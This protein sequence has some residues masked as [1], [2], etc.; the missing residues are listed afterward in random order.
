MG[1]S[2]KNKTVK[3]LGWHFA[4]EKIMSLVTREKTKKKKGRSVE[5]PHVVHSIKT[6]IPVT[7]VCVCV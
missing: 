5:R 7:R 1:G 3:T 6:P 2:R 4:L